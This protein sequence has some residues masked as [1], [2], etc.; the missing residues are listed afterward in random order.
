VPPKS[1]RA[2]GAPPA[3]VIANI[4]T[5]MLEAVSQPSALDMGTWHCGTTH[6]RAGWA[7]TLAG[8]EG[9]ALEEF[10]GTEQAAMQIYK[11]SGSPINPARFY[12]DNASAMADMKRLAEEEAATVSE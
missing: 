9:K 8:E 12:D 10:F 1:G 11:A 6:C 4:H 3:P 7:V 5:K 2:P